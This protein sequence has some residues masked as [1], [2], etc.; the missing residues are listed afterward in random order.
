MIGG[1]LII[2]QSDVSKN[3]PF[4]AQKLCQQKYIKENIEKLKEFRLFIKNI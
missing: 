4:I 1:R 3:G 2:C